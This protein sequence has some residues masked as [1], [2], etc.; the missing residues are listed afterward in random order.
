MIRNF[1]ICAFAAITLAISATSSAQASKRDDAEIK[2]GFEALT[3]WRSEYIYRG[4]QLADNTM[5][6]QLAGQVAL[7]NT[8]SIDVGLFHGTATSSG[9]FSETGAYIDFSRNIGDLT[10]IAKLAVRDYSN[11]DRGPAS[12]F[13]SGADIG[14]AILWTIND[15]VDLTTHLSYDTGAEGLYLESK[16][17][18]YLNISDDS[19]VIFQGGLSAVADYYDRDGINNA[20][21]K[22]EY[23]YNISDAVSVSPFV[24]A[25]LGIVDE[26]ESHLFGGIYF[27]VSF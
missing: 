6:F 19:Y 9:D 23:T 14:G 25:S 27:A 18:Y 15:Q 22:I 10:Y 7:S 20:F 13:K 16:A 2:L 1:S 26:A 12:N 3:S 8:D 11:T 24:S 4:F 21:T 5:E 17:S